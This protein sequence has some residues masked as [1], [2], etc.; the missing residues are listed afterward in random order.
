MRKLS[1]IIILMSL[2]MFLLSGCNKTDF[3]FIQPTRDIVKIELV[4]YN[5]PS[6]EITVI[7]ELSNDEFTSFIRDFKNMDCFLCLGDPETMWTSEGI[8]ITY[9][10]GDYQIINANSEAR[11]YSEEDKLK[12]EGL[13]FFNDEEFEALKD[14]YF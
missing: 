4:I 2:L 7:K 14:K 11:Y 13:Y 9:K 1:L 5:Y 3:P 10:N 8:K 6:D 12:R